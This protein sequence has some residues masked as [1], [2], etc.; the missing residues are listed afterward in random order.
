VSRRRHAPL[1]RTSELQDLVVRVAGGR[2]GDR[3]HPATRTFQALRIAVNDESGC[4]ERVLGRLV[5]WLRDG[6]RV[7]VVAFHSGEDRVVKRWL[8]D[9]V[10]RGTLEP[11]ARRVIEAGEAEIAANPRSRSAK[12]RAARR[13]GTAAPAAGID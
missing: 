9:E 3:I 12:L 5:G 7:A 10:A 8:R 11:L 13:I 2:R 4:L 1:R 6:G